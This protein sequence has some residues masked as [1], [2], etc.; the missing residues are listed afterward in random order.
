MTAPAPAA[1]A[2][3][4]L[5]NGWKLGG[6]TI[7]F[8]HLARRLARE[9][10]PVTLI[11]HARG[12]AF[13]PL[14][15]QP[16][17]AVRRL[18]C[19][20]R[21]DAP[22]SA[23]LIRRRALPVYARVAP[24]TFLPSD[25]VGPFAACALLARRRPEDVRVI[26]VGHGDSERYM[27]WLA[28]YEPLAQFLVAV[29][30]TQAGQLRDA[31]PGR[32]ADILLRPC[33][34]EVP[35]AL[36]RG[37]APPGAPLTLVYAGRLADGD[38]GV[39]ALVPLAEALARRGADFRLRI[40][41]EGPYRHC[42]E[43]DL[44]RAG[45][46]VRRRVALEPPVPPAAMAGVWRTADVVVLVSRHESTG[47]AMLE[48]MAQGCVPVA[49]R[50]NGPRDVIE[51]GRNGCLADLGDVEG[52]AAAI[53]ELDA[54]RERLAA[55]GARAWQ[56]ARERFDFEDYGPWFAALLDEAWRRPARPWP[57]GRPLLPPESRSRGWVRRS[58]GAVWRAVRRRLAAARGGT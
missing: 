49:T 42:L 37:Y 1:G 30:S 8:L 11:E 3:F 51:H 25:A 17:P 40:L 35:A 27:R 10:R 20:Q 13:R 15:E 21:W 38:K 4:A 29:N 23:R 57:A 41:G 24:A 22:V 48:G 45:E 47:L 12:G 16:D 50:C 5:G 34:V 9:G 32:A 28:Y 39:G 54:R 46:A 31:L 2:A 33:P 7:W 44:A 6:T 19:P 52:L 36:A 43:R 18:P 14:E 55:V 58:A 56:T 26:A 53:A